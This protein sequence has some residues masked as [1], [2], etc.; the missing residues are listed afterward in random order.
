M[1]FPSN[2]KNNRFKNSLLCTQDDILIQGNNSFLS[3]NWKFIFISIFFEARSICILSYILKN[4]FIDSSVGI[5]LFKIPRTLSAQLFS[6]S[7]PL[8]HHTLRAA[9][10]AQLISLLPNHILLLYFISLSTSRY[11]SSLISNP[12]SRRHIVNNSISA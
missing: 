6:S 9:R 2:E 1:L 5:P 4:L 12:F 10:H 8:I 7:S 11:L 3:Y